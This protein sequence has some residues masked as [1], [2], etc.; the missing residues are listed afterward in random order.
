MGIP[1]VW[2]YSSLPA[3]FRTVITI[4]METVIPEMENIPIYMVIFTSIPQMGMNSIQKRV[5]D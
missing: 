1:H 3:H 4:R 5:G 2:E